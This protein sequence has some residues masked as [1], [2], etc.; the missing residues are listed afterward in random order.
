MDLYD[1]Y[2]GDASYYGPLVRRFF[3]QFT[4]QVLDVTDGM[5]DAHAVVATAW[6]TAYPVYNDPCRGKRFYLVQDFEPW[7]YPVGGLSVLAENTYRMGFHAI[8]AGPFLAAKLVAEYGMTADAFDFGCDTEHYRLIEVDA[9]RDGIVFY[10]RP[11]TPRRAFE[12][13]V[14]ALQ[15]F[16]ARH[17]EITIHMYGNRIGQL[18]FPFI[19]HGVLRPHELN[20]IYN[21]CIAGLSLSMTNV[22]LVPHE[23]LSAGCI[24]VVNDADHNRIVLDNP[25]VRYAPPTPHGLVTALDEVLANNT[26]E[27]R[28]SASRSVSS[29]S[30]GAAC[31]VVEQAMRRALLS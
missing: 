20:F 8:T 11:R 12:L 9:A 24:P 23:M 16:A 27:Q 25:F 21:R 19:D 18:P 6:Q 26:V 3:P 22:S 13:G 29:A 28:I 1:A 7:F 17:P 4:G 15:L 14:M 5:S 30:W 2:G 31:A 10:A